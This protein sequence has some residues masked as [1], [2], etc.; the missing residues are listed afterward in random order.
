[1]ISIL[2]I[3]VSLY[4]NVPL[5]FTTNATILQLSTLFIVLFSNGDLSEM[6]K[7]G[8]LQTLLATPLPPLT[9]YL[10]KFM[11]VCLISTLLN[12][13]IFSSQ[14]ITECLL[15]CLG[16]ELNLNVS[17]FYTCFLIFIILVSCSYWYNAITVL[18][19]LLFPNSKQLQGISTAVSFIFII[20]IITILFHTFS[21]QKLTLVT[22][23]IGLVSLTGVILSTIIAKYAFR[24]E[25]T[26]WQ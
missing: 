5:I 6:Q 14:R 9:I 19:A 21:Y 23:I 22:A 25:G 16:Y 3:P 7:D 1:M 18:S 24:I 26:R 8:T 13:S 12:V 2:L 10:G 20:F 17:Y 15:R 4:Y 11:R